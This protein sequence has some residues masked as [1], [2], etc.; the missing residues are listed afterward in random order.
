MPP[1]GGLSC[2]HPN[3]TPKQARLEMKRFLPIILLALAILSSCDER[4]KDV[5][6]EKK[7]EDVLYDYHIMQGVIEQLP[8]EDKEQK[9]QDYINAVFKK[10][11]ISHADFERALVYYNRHQKELYSIYGNVKNR[12]QEENDK[13]QTL[14][15]SNSMMAV[16]TEGG[17][18]TNLWNSERVIV[19]RN[20]AIMNKES[21]IL[22]AD[23]SFHQNDKFILTFFPA[24]IG[25]DKD[26]YHV[27]LDYGL[28]VMY[29][30]GKHIGVTRSTRSGDLQQLTL[31]AADAEKIKS[32]SGFFYFYGK[33]GS[34]NLCVVDDIQ[35]IRM[36]SK[37]AEPKEKTDSL[38]ADSTSADTL[39]DLKGERLS[40]EQLR[41]LNKSDKTIK[42][43]E[44]P[45]MRHPNSIGPRR[46]SPHPAS[47]PQTLKLSPE[48]R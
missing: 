44:A 22:K 37:D 27:H 47:H 15:G 35:L 9:A 39:P 34:R 33:K 45:T 28:S 19:L 48:S 8:S 43:Q 38:K 7:M 2:F 10:H 13:L 18:T 40:P 1:Q 41:M 25:E 5:M 31:E 20:K 17:D 16:F 12:L 21:F 46:R 26:D 4:P 29:A 30:N 42:I 3:S 23:T 14:N 24:I 11:N 32:V 6:S 36:H